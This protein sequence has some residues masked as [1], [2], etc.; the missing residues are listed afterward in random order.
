MIPQEKTT[1]H[2]CK[3][4]D[5][6]KHIISPWEEPKEQFNVSNKFRRMISILL[7]DCKLRERFYLEQNS[8]TSNFVNYAEFSVFG[9]PLVF[10]FH[11]FQQLHR[12]SVAQQGEPVH[13]H[14][15]SSKVQVDPEPAVW[16]NQKKTHKE[17]FIQ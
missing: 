3:F 5:L 1:L 8:A 15:C 16:F 13:H 10:S 14:L 9:Q 7:S 11:L 12:P 6:Y 4:T 17:L 2:I